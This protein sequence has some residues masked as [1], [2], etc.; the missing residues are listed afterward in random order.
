MWPGG[1]RNET[2]S[3]TRFL[4]SLVASSVWRDVDFARQLLILWRFFWAIL[5]LSWIF[6][7]MCFWWCF[8]DVLVMFRRCLAGFCCFFLMFAWFV[9]RL[10]DLFDMF[11]WVPFCFW[12]VWKDKPGNLKIDLS[13]HQQARSGRILTI[14]WG[15]LSP[16]EWLFT[17]GA[18]DGFPATVSLDLLRVRQAAVSEF[19]LRMLM[20]CWTRWMQPFWLSPTVRW[21]RFDWVNSSSTR[22]RRTT[23]FPADIQTKFLPLAFKHGMFP[24]FSIQFSTNL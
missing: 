19:L 13:N 5:D 16:M 10:L 23:S 9:G 2:R 15:H 8:G 24:H 14:C 22:N 7:I 3:L 1:A 4:A 17:I 11:F 12:K 20:A 18:Q 21:T 6:W